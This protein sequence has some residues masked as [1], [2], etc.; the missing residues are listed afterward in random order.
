MKPSG[1]NR[2]ALLDL[3]VPLCLRA[4]RTL[5]RQQAGQSFFFAK[6]CSITPFYFACGCA[7]RACVCPD[8]FD[9]NDLNKV[10]RNIMEGLSVKVFRTYNASIHFERMLREQVGSASMAWEEK[11]HS[12]TIFNCLSVGEGAYVWVCIHQLRRKSVSPQSLLLQASC[13]SL[14]HHLKLALRHHLKLDET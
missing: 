14:R 13:F 12:S 10:L 1:S 2:L 8:S 5:Q 4:H 3:P 11:G 7:H 6:C 9:A